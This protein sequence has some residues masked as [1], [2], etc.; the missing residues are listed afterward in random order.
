MTINNKFQQWLTEVLRGCEGVEQPV[1]V[2][3][4]VKEEAPTGFLSS[5]HLATAECGPGPRTEQLF[6]KAAHEDGDTARLVATNRMD[7]LELSFYTD[8]LPHLVSFERSHHTGSQSE[9]LKEMFPRFYAGSCSDAGHFHLVLENVCARGLRMADCNQGLDFD[10]AST[11]I[12]QVKKM[13]G[14]E[15][16][17]MIG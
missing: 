8:I 4:L 7:T 2:T 6:I 9:Q 15:C 17:Y 5:V 13:L 12:R 10:Q 1:E 3:S 14:L 11:M 16:I